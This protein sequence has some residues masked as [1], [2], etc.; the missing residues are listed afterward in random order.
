MNMQKNLNKLPAFSICVYCGSRTGVSAQFA[1]VAQQ[2]GNWIGSHQGQLVYG[3]GENGLMGLVAKSTMQSGGRVVGVIPT[4]LQSKEK[5]L[6]DCD[7]LYVVETMHERKQIMAER[8]DAFLAL[9]GGIGTFEEFFEIWTWRQ[10]GYHDKPIGLLNTEGYYDGL[11]S[12]VQTSVE[13]GFLS[14][15]QMALIK[16]GNHV[17][18]LLRTL[19]QDAGFSPQ[20]IAKGL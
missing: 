5:P 17:E 4:A 10:L 16:T 2:V 12:F 13:K 3:G 11:L 1:Q 19:V 15:S 20:S 7:E 18:E 9:P 8:A 6:F 14:E